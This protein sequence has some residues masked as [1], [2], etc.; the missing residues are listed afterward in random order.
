MNAIETDRLVIRNFTADDWRDLQEM[1]VQYEASE[2]GLYDHEWPTSSEEI[3]GVT[4]WFAGGDS[5]LAASLKTTGKVIGF[6]AL[7][8]EDKPDQV[9]FNLG[10]VFNSDYHGQGYATEGCRAM[11]ERAFGE[12]V[13][14]SV[15]TGTAVANQASCRLLKKLGLHVTGESTG[16][17]RTTADGKPIEFLGQTYAISRDEW[18][19]LHPKT[20]MVSA[21]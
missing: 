8:R 1:I 13:A 3:K 19:L 12:L 15:V 14:D 20:V 17:M 10:Y 7:N 18:L 21:N 11:L 4:G 9:E 5:F 2:V 16:S 6:I